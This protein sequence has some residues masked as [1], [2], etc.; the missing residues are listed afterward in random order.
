MVGAK[1]KH[2]KLLHSSS[3]KRAQNSKIENAYEKAIKKVS[4]FPFL[5]SF[6]IVGEWR[7]KLLWFMIM[8]RPLWPDPNQLILVTGGNI[9]R[10]WFFSLD[11]GTKLSNLHSAT[12]SSTLHKRRDL[13]AFPWTTFGCFLVTQY[14]L[15]SLVDVSSLIQRGQ[16]CLSFNW[17]LPSCLLVMA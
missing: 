14:L 3:L 17:E 4:F 6:V 5:F 9:L 13:L 11:A 12:C 15:L 16:F 2:I 8:C 7:R 1:W 10:T